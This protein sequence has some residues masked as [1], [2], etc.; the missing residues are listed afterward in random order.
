LF[1]LQA[2]RQN[3]MIQT[4]TYF[5]YG[6][7]LADEQHFGKYGIVDKI[8][9]S[10]QGKHRQ[11]FIQVYITYENSCDAAFAIRVTVI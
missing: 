1:Q 5:L 6:K 11:A 3:L 8:I 9:I 2:Y 10:T 4:Y 7:L